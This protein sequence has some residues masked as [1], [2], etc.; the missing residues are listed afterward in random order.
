MTK[1]DTVGRWGGREKSEKAKEMVTGRGWVPGTHRGIHMR[2]SGHSLGKSAEASIPPLPLLWRTQLALLRSCPRVGQV[3]SPTIQ[4]GLPLRG[5]SGTHMTRLGGQGP[6]RHG[7]CSESHS[8]LGQSEDPVTQP[9]VSISKFP[10]LHHLALSSPRTPI[11]SPPALSSCFLQG[12]KG[13]VGPLGPP[14]PK[15]EKVGVWLWEAAALW[16]PAWQEQAPGALWLGQCGKFMAGSPRLIAWPARA[17]E[18][19]DLHPTWMFW[20]SSLCPAPKQ[21]RTQFLLSWGF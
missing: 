16:Y 15:G 5:I 9:S 7:A 1:R 13:I 6:E 11:L 21:K 10:M 19:L 17:Q 18:P 8:E 12:H 20:V 4:V 3:E 2:G 14:G